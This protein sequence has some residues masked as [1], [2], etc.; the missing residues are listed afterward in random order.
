QV[1]FPDEG[2]A[3]QLLPYL[4]REVR[5]EPDQVEDVTDAK[6]S[7]ELGLGHGLAVGLPP[8]SAPRDPEPGARERS[9]V[10]RVERAQQGSVGWVRDGVL[11][12]APVRHDLGEQTGR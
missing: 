9:E 1:G 2:M 10:I 7:V 5:F 8:L 12:A 4:P 3:R 6:Q 11:V